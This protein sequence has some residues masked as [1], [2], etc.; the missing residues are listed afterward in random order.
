MT[1]AIEALMPPGPFAVLE[2]FGGIGC[3]SMAFME[4]PR[5][6]LIGVVEGDRATSDMLATNLTTWA[7]C[8]QRA[9]PPIHVI[10]PSVTDVLTLVPWDGDVAVFFDP[11]WLEEGQPGA[12]VDPLGYRLSDGETVGQCVHALLARANVRVVAVKVPKTEFPLAPVPGVAVTR[13]KRLKKMDLLCFN[14]VAP[15]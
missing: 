5:G 11:P 3:N 4:S 12:Y 14:K 8:L 2:V 13:H 6:R 9:A 7:C 1:A 15:L 10:R